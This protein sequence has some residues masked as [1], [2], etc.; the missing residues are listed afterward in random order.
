MIT[1]AEVLLLDS[2]YSGATS[3]LVCCSPIGAGEGFTAIFH[4][5]VLRFKCA[6]C[7]SRFSADPERFISGHA[8]E[9]CDH[10]DSS[11]YSEWCD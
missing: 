8:A 3:C 1:N 6:G 11:P 10:Q 7:L 4:G 9:C 5:R 2:H